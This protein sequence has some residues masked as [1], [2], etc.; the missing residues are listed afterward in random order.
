MSSTAGG[1]DYTFHSNPSS[2]QQQHHKDQTQQESGVWSA[3]TSMTMPKVKLNMKMLGNL[4]DS[5]D[6]TP[7]HHEVDLEKGTYREVFLPPQISI[8]TSLLKKPEKGKFL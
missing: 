6:T 1:Q 4:V 5:T 3:V 2:S 7:K 8:I